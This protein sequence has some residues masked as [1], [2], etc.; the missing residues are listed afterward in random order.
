ML[1]FI[2][3]D[4]AYAVIMMLIHKT[5][6]NALVECLGCHIPVTQLVN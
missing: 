5:R 4:I 1:I 3:I 6:E 2:L